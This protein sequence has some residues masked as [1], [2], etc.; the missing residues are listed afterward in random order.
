MRITAHPKITPAPSLAVNCLSVFT[1][2]AELCSSFRIPLYQSCNL[3]SCLMFRAKPQVAFL[4]TSQYLKTAARSF[5]A[6][7][8]LVWWRSSIW[9]LSD[10]QLA[11]YQVHCLA[12]MLHTLSRHNSDSGSIVLATVF[13]AYVLFNVFIEDK[14]EGFNNV[15]PAKNAT[16]V[17]LLWQM[18][19]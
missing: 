6:H 15:Q 4:I 12:H 8:A 19:P 5:L 11:L 13:I 17:F 10:K 18:F 2:V 1:D 3:L 16:I 7:M 9:N 14:P